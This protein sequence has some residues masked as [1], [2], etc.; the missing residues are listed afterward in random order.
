MTDTTAVTPFLAAAALAGGLEDWGPLAEATGE[1]MQT[2]GLTLWSAG[3][4]E[5]GVWECTPGPSYWTLE[6]S[7][8]IYIVSG[9]MTVT[10]DGGTPQDIGPGDTAVF[11]RGWQ[12]RWQIHETIRKLYVLF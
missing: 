9:R 7:E 12:G 6:T 10:P 5:V 4:Q 11:P 8:A 3:G 1:A 2:S